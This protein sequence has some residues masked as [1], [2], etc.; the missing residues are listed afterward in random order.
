[1]RPAV[2]IKRSCRARLTV[3]VSNGQIKSSTIIPED[4]VECVAH[5]HDIVSDQGICFSVPPVETQKLRPV[6]E[7]IDHLRRLTRILPCYLAQVPHG[8]EQIGEQVAILPVLT[9]IGSII[10]L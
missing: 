1:M 2:L 7:R 3:L 9:V 6:L 8:H 5:R 10:G 4:N